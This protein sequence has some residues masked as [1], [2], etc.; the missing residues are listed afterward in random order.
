MDVPNYHCRDCIHFRQCKRIDHTV[1]K[2]AV[3]WFKTYDGDFHIVCS[4][5]TPRWQA[6]DYPWT[7]FEDYWKVYV[8]QWLPY[9]NTNIRVYFTIHGDASIRYGVPLMDYV[10]GSMF[11]GNI[12]KAVEKMYYKQVRTGFGYRLIREPIEGVMIDGS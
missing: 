5:F 7:G 6:P 4:D 8:E 9:S 1:V 12:L 10:N 2:F 11:D 3:P